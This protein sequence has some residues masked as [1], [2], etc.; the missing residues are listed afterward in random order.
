MDQEKPTP[1]SKRERRNAIHIATFTPSG[2]RQLTEVAEASGVSRNEAVI[3]A[4]E[5]WV[6]ERKARLDNKVKLSVPV[7]ARMLARL[8]RVAQKRKTTVEALVTDLVLAKIE[9][10]YKRKSR[11]KSEG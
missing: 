5:N 6:A 7:D 3:Q 11:A 2:L 4:C 10:E 1:Y 8:A 9:E